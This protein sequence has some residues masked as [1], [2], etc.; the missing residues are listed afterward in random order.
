MGSNNNKNQPVDESKLVEYAL[1][2]ETNYKRLEAK[3][4]RRNDLIDKLKKKLE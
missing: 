1:F 4:K 2:L 3:F